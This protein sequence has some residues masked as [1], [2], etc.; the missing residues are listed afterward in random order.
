MSRTYKPLL[1]KYLSGTRTYQFEN[2]RLKIPPGVFHPGFFFSTRYLLDYVRRLPLLG[3]SFFEP[4]CGS[5]LVSILAARMGA[6]VTASDINPVAVDYLKKN[7]EVNKTEMAIIHSDL[8]E[9]I[10]LQAFDIIA[11]N[12]PYYRKR[13]GTHAEYGWHCG[14]DGEFFQK[15]FG[16]L[17]G[18][19][20]SDTETLMVLFEGCDQA[21]IKSY[22]A[23]NGFQLHCVKRHQN[24]LEKN[25]IFKIERT[26]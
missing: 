1:E 19:I 6:R 11:V 13:P 26:K 21:M 24:L 2:I 22:A 20:H 3:K 15:L 10:P 16:G 4:G 17:A 9:K 8:F 12:P 18:Y 5:G 14:E 7:C 23:K 25:F